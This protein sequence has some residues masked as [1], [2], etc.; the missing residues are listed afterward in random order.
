MNSDIIEGNWDQV[1]GEVQK[2]WGKLVGDPLDQINGSRKKLLGA[3]QESYGY[4][5]DEAEKQLRAWEDKRTKH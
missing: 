1:K 4:A 5:R 2:Q 3:L